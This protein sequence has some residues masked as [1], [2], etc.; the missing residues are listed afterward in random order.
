MAVLAN[1]RGE[2]SVEFLDVARRLQAEALNFSLK[3]PKRLTFFL[4]TEIMRWG[5]EVYNHVKAANSI[6]MAR[7]SDAE[8]RRD[9]WIAANN[10]L[11]I[12]DGKISLAYDTLMQ[13]PEHFGEGERDPTKR[14]NKIR[15][16]KT[17]L[18][19][20]TTRL[21]A[22]INEEAVQIKKIKDSDARRMKNLPE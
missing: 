16:G 3:L 15:R 4:S 7:K 20:A 12:L 2:S 1:K 6:Y 10:A 19:K 14:A 11:Q 9:H 22:L 21:T 5:H 8:K 18:E 13:N 17:R